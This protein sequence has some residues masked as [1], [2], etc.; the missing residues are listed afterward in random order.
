MVADCVPILLA[1]VAAGVVAAVHAGRAGMAAGVVAA[2]CGR[3]ARDGA[4]QLRAAVGPCV[5][6]ANYEV[7]AELR[8]QVTRV[9]PAAWGVTAAGTPALDLRAGVHSQLRDCGVA[10]I[11]DV[12]ACTVSDERFYSHRRATA[13]GAGTTGR[14]AGVIVINP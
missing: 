1:D 6:V 8:A 11:V 4:T 7:P 3:L 5:S 2:A 13:Q 9:V 12:E 10:E 14:F